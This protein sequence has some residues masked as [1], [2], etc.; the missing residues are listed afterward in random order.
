[1]LL[2]VLLFLFMFGVFRRKEPQKALDPA[3]HPVRCG[4]R[5]ALHL[6]VHPFAGFWE[7]K[8]EKRGNPVAG[9]VILGLAVLSHLFRQQ[10]SGYLFS[11]YNAAKYNVFTE[12][13]TV[14]LPVFLWVLSNWCLT[15]LMDG[16]GNMKDVYV[17][18]TYSLAP[19]VL[20][21]PLTLI[22]NVMSLG[23]ASYYQFFLSLIFVWVGLLIFFS[24]MITH[25]YSLLK[26]LF[27]CGLILVGI[28][29]ILFI[30]I[31]FYNLIQRIMS[32]VISSWQE[33]SFHIS[34]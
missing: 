31:L 8:H 1:M 30:G 17:A 9:T 34:G 13:L 20:L 10:Y 15:T 26:T 27:T 22:S 28:V 23:E 2:L 4:L 5:Y 12:I 29:V 14:L 25:Q 24:T 18:T 7:L 3:A 11:T 21:I 16:E 19:M 6:P 33:I 32:F